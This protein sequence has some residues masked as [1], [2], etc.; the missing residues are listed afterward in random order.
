MPE[1]KQMLKG[2]VFQKKVQ[3]DFKS[4]TKDGKVIS[5][6]NISLKELKN[7]EQKHGRIDI[8]IEEI[9]DF[10]TIVE[11]KATDWDKIK[12]KNIKRN[13][14]RHQKQIFKYIDRYVNVDHIDTCLGMIYP[15]PPKKKGLKQFIESYLENNYGVPVYWYS[16][17]ETK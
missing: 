6:K 2:K 7:A 13:L 5:E 8:F 3:E 16:E 4:N 9:G 10:V 14:Y 1:P 11:I 17:I 12:S 15:K